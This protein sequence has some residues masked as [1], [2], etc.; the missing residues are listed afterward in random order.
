M[1]RVLRPSGRVALSVYSGIE[2]TPAAH[3]FVQ[4]LDQNLG[5]ESSRIKRAEHDFKE[6]EALGSLMIQAQLKE[7]AVTT[8]VKEIIFPSVF[9]YVRFQLI[10]TPMAGLLADLD[11]TVRDATIQAI[12]ADAQSLLDPEMLRAGRLTFPQEAYVATAISG[13]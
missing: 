1:K 2:R 10:A 8:V 11:D 4:A 9:E 13:G 3:A 5:P 7:V 6:P 12:A